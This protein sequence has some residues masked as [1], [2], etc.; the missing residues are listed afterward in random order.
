TLAHAHDTRVVEISAI[1][2]KPI[3]DDQFVLRYTAKGTKVIDR[4]VPEADLSMKLVELPDGRVI[5]MGVSYR[6]PARQEDLDRVIERAKTVATTKGSRQ[7]GAM[8][9]RSV[10]QRVFL[11]VNVVVVGIVLGFLVRRHYKKTQS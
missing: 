10:T 6:I 2:T 4:T 11:V 5:R 9:R 7:I 8:Q 3:P 1:S